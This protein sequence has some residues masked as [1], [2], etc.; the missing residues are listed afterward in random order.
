VKV[1]P[2]RTLKTDS[3]ASASVGARGV[4]STVIEFVASGTRRGF[5]SAIDKRLRRW[6]LVGLFVAGGLLAS[7]ANQTADAQPVLHT[8]DISGLSDRAQAGTE[9]Y[10]CNF[11]Y[12]SDPGAT[13]TPVNLVDA[14]TDPDITTGTLPDA[15]AATPD[16]RY[17]LVADEG[18]D[19][20]TVVDTSDGDVVARLATGVEPDAVAVSPNGRTALVANADGASVTPVD[21]ETM[22]SEPAVRVGNQPDAIAFGGPGGDTALV[23]NAGDATVTPVDVTNM[24]AGTPIAVGVEPDAITVSPDG[25]TALV[26]NFGSS[27][28]TVIDMSS[29]SA[30]G[31]IAIGVA[32]TGLATKGATAW[33]S[34]G[35]SLVPISFAARAVSGNPVNV[36]RLVEGVAISG[37]DAW[38]A[39]Q[40]PYVTEV[41][42]TDGKVVTSVQVGGRPSAIVIPAPLH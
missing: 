9:A 7:C 1:T 24:T 20:V 3:E 41:D 32:P 28:V 39:D 42:L 8:S 27:S 30:A 5:S 29:L 15:I 4:C 34:G 37:S 12:T 23:A 6:G 19:L 40:G 13:V 31:D 33:A 14:S 18:Q 26:A 16:G 17:V 11:G 10:V 36:G 22:R 35:T 21:L 38:V 2:L 25:G